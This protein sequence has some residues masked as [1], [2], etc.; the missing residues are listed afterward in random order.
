M[1]LAVAGPGPRGQAFRSGR[2]PQRVPGLPG[3]AWG[4]AGAVVRLQAG[5]VAG[6]GPFDGAGQVVPQVPAVGDLDGAVEPLQWRL[7]VAAAAVAADDLRSWVG[8]EPGAEGFGGPFGE[9]VDRPAG[10]DVHQHGAVDVS[11]AQGKVV[12][13]QHQRRSGVGLGCRADEPQ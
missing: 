13:P 10:R 11:V 12:D 8:V 9:H 7:G 1:D 5:T 2:L 4:W 6:D 3:L